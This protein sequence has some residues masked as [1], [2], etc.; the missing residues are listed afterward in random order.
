M[1]WWGPPLSPGKKA[2]LFVIT[3]HLKKCESS[4]RHCVEIVSAT[5]RVG[6]STHGTHRIFLQSELVSEFHWHLCSSLTHRHGWRPDS[7]WIGLG[8]YRISSSECSEI[9]NRSIEKIDLKSW[10]IESISKNNIDFIFYDFKSIFSIYRFEIWTFVNTWKTSWNVG[11]N[12]NWRLYM[13]KFSNRSGLL[14]DLKL[15]TKILSPIGLTPNFSS[16]K[17]RINSNL[18]LSLPN[19][20]SNLPLSLHN[21]RSNLPSILHNRR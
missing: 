11:F 10:K 1:F 17:Y 9:S 8:L 12:P 14:I 15:V 3:Y 18:P 5:K 7:I 20:R 19:W 2:L 4:F 16:S 21:W 13:Q 6:Y